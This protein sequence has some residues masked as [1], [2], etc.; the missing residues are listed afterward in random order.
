MIVWSTKE[1][2][3]R[4]AFKRIETFRVVVVF[5]SVVPVGDVKGLLETSGVQNG[6][7]RRTASSCFGVGGVAILRR[8]RGKVRWW[9][10]GL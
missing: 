1:C 7:S 8:G 4:R 9:L 3:E 5:V 2:L 10:L 6:Q